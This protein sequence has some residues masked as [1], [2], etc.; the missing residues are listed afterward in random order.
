ME[1]YVLKMFWKCFGNVLEM[2]W[3]CFGNV[4]G[5]FRKCFGNVLEMFYMFFIF[6]N[7]YKCLLNVLELSLNVF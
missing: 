4:L 6:F 1:I 7:V 2:F 5:M 3:K